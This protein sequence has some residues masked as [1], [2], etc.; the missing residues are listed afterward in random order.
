LWAEAEAWVAWV[1]WVE[2][3]AWAEAE[4]WVA[5]VE[6]VVAVVVWVASSSSVIGS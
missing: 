5:W 4:A 1:A 6:A 3:E 2:V